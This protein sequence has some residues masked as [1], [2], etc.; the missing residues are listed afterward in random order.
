[1]KKILYIFCSFIGGLFVTSSVFGNETYKHYRT[2]H[3]KAEVTKETKN[4]QV[5]NLE[6]FHFPSNLPGKIVYI[7]V[8]GQFSTTT[9]A[10]LN[11]DGR[12]VT[13]SET[14]FGIEYSQNRCPKEGE[15]V[16]SY[17][18]YANKYQSRGLTGSIVKQTQ[19]N[20]TQT[21]KVD[22]MLPY[23]IPISMGSKGCGIVLFDGSDFNNK[24]YTMKVDLELKYT[25]EP[26]MTSL[27]AEFSID[28]DNQTQRKLNAYEVVEVRSGA[29]T[30]N[31]RVLRPGTIYAVNG[32]IT[33]SG[34]HST[35]KGHWFVR[36]ITAIYKNNSCQR[37]FK[38]HSPG[39]FS[40]NDKTG[41]STIP[42]PSSIFWPDVK[43]IS[44]ATAEGKDRETVITTVKSNKNLPIHIEEGDCV[45]QAALPY[46]D[47]TTGKGTNMNSEFFVHTQ[48][49]PD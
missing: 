36:Y 44:D 19:P 48:S 16:G 33:T 4:F 2:L 24:P 17:Q 11:K 39:N 32:N 35:N 40:W 6:P 20:S 12:D 5:K 14:L 28:A 7:G 3:V 23:G 30:P 13:F 38:N 8:K 41:T 10:K 9:E 29:Y 27:G 43:I 49:I 46:G 45:V 26:I 18:E 31:D 22:V 34:I 21:V 1:M 47:S 42:N 37:A 25:F 15:T